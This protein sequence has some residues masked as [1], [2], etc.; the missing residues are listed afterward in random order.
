MD[1]SK[2]AQIDIRAVAKSNILLKAYY[3]YSNQ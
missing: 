1:R 2:K 3:D